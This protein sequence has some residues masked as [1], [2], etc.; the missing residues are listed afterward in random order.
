MSVAKAK[1]GIKELRL[2]QFSLDLINVC[3]ICVC[4]TLE[5]RA[6]GIKQYFDIISCT[7]EH[8]LLARERLC[9]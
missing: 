7:K 2:R 1:V 8:M 6:H 3:I 4:K 5:T 9:E